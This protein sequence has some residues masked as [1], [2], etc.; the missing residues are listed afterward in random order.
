MFLTRAGIREQVSF[1]IVNNETKVDP[2]VFESS[3]M[4]GR[5]LVETR[6]KVGRQWLLQMLHGAPCNWSYLSP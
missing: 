2:Q 4:L 5:Y 6:A 1:R 3:L